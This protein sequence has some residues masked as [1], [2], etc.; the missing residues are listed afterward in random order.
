MNRP[1]AFFGLAL[2]ALVAAG[3]SFGAWSW[4]GKPVA[5]PDVPNAH[6]QCLSY[7]PASDAGSPLTEKDGVFDVPA[8]LIERDMKILSKYTDCVRTYST[9]GPQGDVLPAAAAVGM[10]VLLGI[11]VS[12]DDVRNQ[13]EIDRAL[14]MAN[15][16]PEAVRAIVVGNEVLLR[17]EMLGDRLAATI[18]AVKARTNL[19]VAY[20]DIYEFWRRNP[21]VGQAVDIALLHI[22][23]YWDDPHPVSIDDVFE[24]VVH[25]VIKNAKEIAIPGKPII[26]GEIGWPSSG[27]TRSEA[28]PTL[29]NEARFMRTLAANADALGVGYNL[30]EAI[31]QPWKRIP[32]GTVGAYWGLL[33]KNR[34]LKFPLT[35]PVREWAEWQ[36]GAAVS[37]GA[38]VI[39]LLIGW[40]NR[41]RMTFARW[42]ALGLA[43]VAAGT[44][45]WILPIQIEQ[46]AAGGF[47]IVKAAGWIFAA[48][49]GT[50][51]LIGRLAIGADW[52]ARVPASAAHVV[53]ALKVKGRWDAATVLGLLN[54]GVLLIAA[55]TAL[56]LAVDGRH[57][58]FATLALWLPALACLIAGFVRVPGERYAEEAW[59]AMVL[60]AASVWSIDHY[61]NIE[62]WIWAATCWAIA[63][64]W[65]GTMRDELKRLKNMASATTTLFRGNPA[66]LAIIVAALAA[67][68]GAAI[69]YQ[70]YE[71]DI[72][73]AICYAEKPWW[74]VFRSFIAVA[75]KNYGFGWTA[76]LLVTIASWRIYTGKSAN[77]LLWIAIVLGGCG[78]ILYDATVSTPA[79]LIATILLARAPE[80]RSA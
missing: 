79:V 78:M 37:F 45:W 47:A 15:K 59:L 28:V 6:F 55:M 40:R 8:G 26:I 20:A 75:S 22:L 77:V 16:H 44:T 80:R 33:D 27:R 29:V 41:A 76:I 11:W 19:P 36:T 10:K 65:T 51:L 56:M 35:G 73:G 5:M 12:T 42:I 9:N 72:F 31:D 24:H 18:K 70:F 48:S 74:C 25:P 50:A 53:A 39:A 30:I 68:V 57:R 69:R 64:P 49:I 52:P 60:V 17:R 3:A 46:T 62:A 66:L 61:N 43:G 38:A 63:V 32:E 34:E 7:T 4:L 71:P 1:T 21:Q 54:T 14:D 58:D 13:I 23:P 2:S 67:C